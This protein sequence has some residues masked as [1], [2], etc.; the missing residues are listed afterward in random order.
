MA[1]DAES[2]LMAPDASLSGTRVFWI[3]LDARMDRR[4]DMETLLARQGV[5]GATR[6]SA[7]GPEDARVR[8]WQEEWPQWKARA[9]AAGCAVSHFECWE[10][11]LRDETC[12]RA[13]IL[14]DDVRFLRGWRRQLGA[15]LQR[16]PA[17]WEMLM[18]DC[19]ALDEPWLP[20]PPWQVDSEDPEV[21][22][23]PCAACVF[24]DAYLLTRAAAQWC[25]AQRAE[26]PWR[27]A[28]GILVSM[29][30]RGRSFT[31]MPKLAL[32]RWDDSN[33]QPGERVRSLHDFY[34]G[35]YFKRY[36]EAL[37]SGT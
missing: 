14:E 26:V 6:I 11:F 29:Q 8:V 19:R 4:E 20:G 22:V 16:L 32:Q 17:D 33:I 27:D 15:T 37:Y 25:V 34:S 23:Q 2:S 10:H 31:T 3:N 36:P 12:E 18:L 1:A 9:G 5:C 35:T 30:E 28:E 21:Q 7:A 24:T 13:L